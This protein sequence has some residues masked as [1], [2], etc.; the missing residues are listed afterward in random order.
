MRL[1]PS[2]ATRI[3]PSGPI[4]T[5]EGWSNSASA[6]AP[7]SPANPATPGVP[8]IT[9]ETPPLIRR[10]TCAA[11]SAIS[12][13]PSSV[14]TMPS[15]ASRPVSAVAIVSKFWPSALRLVPS[16]W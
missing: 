6:A 8:A 2:S 3:A 10:M 1:L 11:E 7:P 15:G 12:W 4:A 9:V 16:P 5:S 13:S 14:T